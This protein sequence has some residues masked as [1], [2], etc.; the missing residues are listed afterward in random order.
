MSST[1]NDIE[2]FQKQVVEL[3]H[4]GKSAIQTVGVY[5]ILSGAIYRWIKEFT[6][7]VTDEGKSINQHDICSL[8]HKN[9]HLFA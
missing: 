1:G 4:R 9:L 6:P 7:I 5:G 3:Y 2:D 8:V